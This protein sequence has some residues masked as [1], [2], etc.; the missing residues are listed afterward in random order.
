M[1]VAGGIH[2]DGADAEALHIEGGTL[3]LRHTCEREYRRRHPDQ[4]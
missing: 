3:G 1:Y 2:A 4:R